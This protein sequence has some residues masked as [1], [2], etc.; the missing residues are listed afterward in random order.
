LFPN[1]GWIQNPTNSPDLPT[2]LKNF[3]LSL[4]VSEKAIEDVKNICL[5]NGIPYQY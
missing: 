2:Q 1:D 3:E 4:I 5:N